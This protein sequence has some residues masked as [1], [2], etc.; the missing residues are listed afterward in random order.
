ML[1]L[2]TCRAGEQNNCFL[3]RFGGAAHIVVLDRNLCP[4][5]IATTTFYQNA[6]FSWNWTGPKWRIWDNIF[7]VDV[8]RRVI[9]VRVPHY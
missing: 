1:D 3:L 4:D 6:T 2:L 7:C 5:V 9:P 8:L